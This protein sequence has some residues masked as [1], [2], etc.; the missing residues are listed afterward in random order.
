[1]LKGFTPDQNSKLRAV[2]DRHR[3]EVP[4]LEQRASAIRGEQGQAMEQ[5]LTTKQLAEIQHMPSEK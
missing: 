1:M 4:R 2:F 3:A 5:I